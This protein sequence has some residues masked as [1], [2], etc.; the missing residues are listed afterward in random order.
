MVCLSFLLL[1]VLERAENVEML[2]STV[3]WEVW[4]L[5]LNFK[6]CYGEW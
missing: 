3:R 1:L 6:E 4:N 5:K 2:M